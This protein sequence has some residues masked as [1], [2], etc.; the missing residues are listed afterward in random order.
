MSYQKEET[1]SLMKNVSVQH[2]QYCESEDFDSHLRRRC[3]NLPVGK[4]LTVLVV[5]LFGV[6][7][8][9]IG[10]LVV[11][12]PTTH[13]DIDDADVKAMVEVTPDGQYHVHRNVT[14]VPDE[15]TFAQLATELLPPWYQASLMAVEDTLDNK[16][17]NNINNNHK[18]SIAPDQVQG[19]RKALLMTRDLLDVFAPVFATPPSS[20]NLWRKLRKLYKEGYEKVG[21]L[22][23][24][25]HSGVDYSDALLRQRVTQVLLW[26]DEFNTFQHKHR[27]SY[28]FRHA[29]DTNTNKC[30]RHAPLAT[31]QKFWSNDNEDLP[32]GSDLALVTLRQLAVLQLTHAQYYWNQI[33]DYDSVVDELREEHFHN[34]RKQLRAHVD[35]FGGNTDSPL[36]LPDILNTGTTEMD[37]L[38]KAQHLLGA[39]NDLWTAY[40]IYETRGTHGKEQ[41]ELVQQMDDAWTEFR[42]W[43]VDKDLA[44]VIQAALDS[45][46]STS[47]TDVSTT[48]SLQP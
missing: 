16:K 25:D 12:R 41:K 11:G 28:L 3:Y 39:I 26:R 34:L 14:F 47:T 10:Q 8:L 29:A 37:T 13:S 42:Q 35:V 6:A 46:T 20:R 38:D 15:T 32:C 17:N 33:Q 1:K 43:A 45:S 4:I 44:G 31:S 30:N 22:Q 23:D 40:H 7:G 5:A 36:L 27:I 48:S 24:L 18:N 19:C 9:L 2:Y 21:Y